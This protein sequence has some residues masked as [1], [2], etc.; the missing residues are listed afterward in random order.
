M[1][2]GIEL[3][4]TRS[5]ETDGPSPSLLAL[6]GLGKVVPLNPSRAN[7]EQYVDFGANPEPLGLLEQRCGGMLALERSDRNFQHFLLKSV[8][9]LGSH[10]V[11]RKQHSEEAVSILSAFQE[12][13][14][15]PESPFNAPRKLFSLIDVAGNEHDHL[16]FESIDVHLHINGKVSKKHTAYFSRLSADNATSPRLSIAIDDIAHVTLAVPGTEYPHTW[17]G[18]QA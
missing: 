14:S 7:G 10:F 15:L 4:Q 18:D 11:V 8:G 9:K 6:G 13:S 17:Q 5:A 12:T 1:G 16:V 3:A 2:Q